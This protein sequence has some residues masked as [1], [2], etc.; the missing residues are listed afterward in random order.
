MAIS[1]WTNKM[2]YNLANILT[3]KHSYLKISS[4]N[5]DFNFY[6]LLSRTIKEVKEIA[7]QNLKMD[8][9]KANKFRLILKGLILDESK[10]LS[11]LN[12]PEKSRLFLQ[13]T[14]I[15]GKGLE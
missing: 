6:F 7:M 5:G 10:T 11:E 2:L 1:K 15:S 12:I 8:I 3:L 4:M 14:D 13:R 9:T